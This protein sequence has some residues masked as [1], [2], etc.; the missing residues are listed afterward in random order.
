MHYYKQ[1]RQ[2]CVNDNSVRVYNNLNMTSILRKLSLSLFHDSELITVLIVT[3][4]VWALLYAFFYYVPVPWKKEPEETRTNTFLRVSLRKPVWTKKDWMAVLLITS[5]YAVVSLH[6]LGSTKFPHTTWQPSDTPQQVIFRLNEITKFDAVCTI[7]GEGDN[8]SNPDTYQLGMHDIRLEGSND[9]SSWE[10]I[11]TLSS[12]SIY[13]YAFLKG[14]WDY[15]Y[16]RMTS[17]NKNDTLSEI[18]F[19][20]SK[21]ERFLGVE[22]YEDAFSGSAYPASL[23]VDEQ[24][25]MCLDPTYMNEG[26]FDEVYHPR[27]AWEIANGQ[28]MYASVHPLL[29]TSMIALSIRLFG[30]NPFAWRFPGALTGILLLP[31]FYALCKDMFR[32]SEYAVLGTALFAADF[33]HLTT[34][35]IATLEP[36]S[37]FW[38]L[39]MFRIMVRYYYTGFY[40]TSLKHQMKI[41]CLCGIAMGLGIATKWT[42]CY[43]AVGLAIILFSNLFLRWREYHTA[44][45]RL[46]KPG[47][48]PEREKKL[49]RI[50]TKVFD[51]HLLITLLWCFVFFIFIPVII[52]IV[53][54]SWTHVWRDGFSISNVWKQVMYMYRYHIN[55]EATH[56]YQSSWYQWLLDLRPIWYYGHGEKSGV[57]HSIACFSNPLLCI[58][59]FFSVFVTIWQILKHRDRDAWLIMIG[60]LTALVPWVSLVE[61]CVFAYHFYPTSIFMILSVVHTCRLLCEKHP[62]FRVYVQI[63]ACMCI[64]LFYMFLPATAGF[65]T[66]RS[67]IKLLEWLPGWYFG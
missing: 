12:G 43:S 20:A 63:F 5:A 31:L 32:R 40:D 8:N 9:L 60:Y 59:G 47:E 58:A 44:V 18:A 7:Y 24:D 45:I 33:M 11:G 62:E 28:H 23:L 19:K 10:E 61:R 3:G 17:D 13:Q 15:E 54:Y 6:Q 50:I 64:I 49:C 42:A 16:I 55:L 65:G 67:Y 14:E 2:D 52:Y 29:G 30:M 46:R 35:R 48:L 38:I 1:N 39:L 21:A 25:V 4:V 37:V 22:V 56:P 51:D 26:Y 36:F 57:Y 66:D 53:S 41:L 27:N 34:S